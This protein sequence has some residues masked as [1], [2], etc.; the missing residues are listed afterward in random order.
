MR[1]PRGGYPSDTT[2]EAR[3][4]HVH[5]HRSTAPHHHPDHHLHL[6]VRHSRTHEGPPK[7]A[8][9]MFA[10][11]IG[12]VLH[13]RD[14]YRLRPLVALL[15]FVGDACSLRQRAVAVRVDA[16]V[17]DE[18]VAVALVRRDEAEPLVV[19][20]PFVGSGCYLSQSSY[21]PRCWSGPAWTARNQAGRRP[22]AGC[23]AATMAP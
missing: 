13:G 2:P 23:E 17:M 10:S 8:F 9:F 5:R 12:A 6:N 21:F 19:A 4:G 7:R 15:L 18:Q 20:E 16:A 3:R 11:A 22:A 14:V 1:P